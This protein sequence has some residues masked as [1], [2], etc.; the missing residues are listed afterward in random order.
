M[1]LKYKATLYET[2]EITDFLY[3][4]QIKRE[5]LNRPKPIDST[6]LDERCYATAEKFFFNKKGWRR[7]ET[8]HIEIEEK[9][10]AIEA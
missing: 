5:E 6:L 8:L 7:G 2:P 9:P 10:R 3:V 4:S 1:S